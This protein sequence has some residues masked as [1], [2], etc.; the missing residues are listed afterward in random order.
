MSLEHA[1]LGFLTYRPMSGY[2]LKKIFDTSVRHFWPADQAQIYRTLNWLSEKGWADVEVVEQ[3]D[4]PDRKVYHITEAGREELRQWLTTPLPMAQSR[5]APMI[6]VFFAGQLPDEEVIAM[7][8]RAAEHMRML[9]QQYD[10]IPERIDA[11]ADYVRSPREFF[12]WMLTL[13]IG[14]MTARTNLEWIESII[15]RIRNGDI[16][17]EYLSGET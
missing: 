11:Y 1:I 16:P 5:S 14:K 13:E 17:K 6:Q 2:D 15:Q 9:L 12:F 10:R 4:R 7:F 8:E 3:E